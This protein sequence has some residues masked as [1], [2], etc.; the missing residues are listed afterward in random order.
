MMKTRSRLHSSHSP[1]RSHHSN[2]HTRTNTRDGRPGVNAPPSNPNAD[3][4]KPLNL[5][6]KDKDSK[7]TEP[8]AAGE[9]KGDVKGDGKREVGSRKTDSKAGTAMGTVNDGK[10]GRDS[11][12]RI[13][14]KLQTLKEE[15]QE[16][17]K[18]DA[19]LVED[20]KMI[21]HLGV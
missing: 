3:N 13:G 9:A 21:Q 15:E 6:D 16:R 19:R 12:T 2:R 14:M 4:L 20:L 10:E 5:K 8:E 1:S 11:T 17:L 18:E 7:P